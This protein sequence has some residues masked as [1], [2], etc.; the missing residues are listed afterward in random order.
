MSTL[1]IAALAGIFLAGQA[2]AATPTTP[3]ARYDAAMAELKR[4][5]DDFCG[6]G[7][8]KDPAEVK[9][10][11]ALWNAT[12]DWAVAFLDNH[13]GVTAE[14]LQ[15]EFLNRHRE[16]HES[17]EPSDVVLL[18]PDLYAFATQWGETGNVFVVG[19]REDHWAVVWDIA[20]AE[21]GNFPTLKG[22]RSTAAQTACRDK[23]SNCG[24]FYGT[25]FALKPDRQGRVRFGVRAIYA[26]MAGATVGGQVSFWRWD[27]A[28]GEP[29]LAG[30]FAVMADDAGDTFAPEKVTI[31]TKHDFKTFYGCGGCVGRQLD[32]TFRVLPDRIVDEGKKPVVPELDAVDELLFRIAH[33]KPAADLAGPGVIA[34]LTKQI[35]PAKG[36]DGGFGMEMDRKIR[37]SAN[38]STVCLLVDGLPMNTF[39]LERRQGRFFITDARKTRANSRGTCP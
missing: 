10:L 14:K 23:S 13:P 11:D 25:A 37:H 36:D 35:E 39:V 17:V 30:T 18:A 24:P 33:R 32:W 20:K 16:G 6:W 4:H 21:T 22:W 27:G 1:R 19:K 9:A 28:K 38:G 26:Q 15:T 12:Q 31:R 5:C 7:L 8:G 3:E 34:T 2:F 29:L